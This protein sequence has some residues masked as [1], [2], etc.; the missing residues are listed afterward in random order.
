MSSPDACPAPLSENERVALPVGD[1]AAGLL[2]ENA[3]R[4]KVPVVHRRVIA[5]VDVRFAPGDLVIADEDGVVVIPQAVEAEAIGR[6]WEKVHAEN[7]TRDAIKSGMK[8]VTAYEKYG[9]L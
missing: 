7:V 3:P 6:A 1:A 4:A 9:V 2:D 5:E 8:A